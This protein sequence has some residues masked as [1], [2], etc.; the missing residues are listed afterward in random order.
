MDGLSGKVKTQLVLATEKSLSNI[1]D[2]ALTDTV[3]TEVCN[4]NLNGEIVQIQVK[5]TRNHGEFM[6]DDESQFELIQAAGSAKQF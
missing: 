3:Y 2:S 1:K 5:V 6:K 4:Y